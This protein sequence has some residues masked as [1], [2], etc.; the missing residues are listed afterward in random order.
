[1]GSRDSVKH[2]VCDPQWRALCSSSRAPPASPGRSIFTR[3]AHRSGLIRAGSRVI[4]TGLHQV[5]PQP[6]F[7]WRVSTPAP[8][9]TVPSTLRSPAARARIG[10]YLTPETH[11]LIDA[12]A[13]A[14]TARP[15]VVNTSR[16]AVVNTRAVIQA[17]KRHAGQPGH[18]RVRGGSRPFLSRPLRRCDPGRRVRAPFHLPQG[19]D[20]GAPAS[21]TED[22][23]GAF[24]A[25]TMDNLDS[26]EKRGAALYP[27]SVERLA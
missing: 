1:M 5:A 4:S 10:A 11:H 18:G 8:E 15:H 25:M 23:L 20:H 21:C 22:A 17:L 2:R 27:V 9:T 13:L 12:A 7:N 3:S 16:G 19:A 14:T 24:A 6:A 26:L